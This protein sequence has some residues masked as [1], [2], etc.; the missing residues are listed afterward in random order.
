MK[1][2]HDVAFRAIR[3]AAAVAELRTII[4]TVPDAPA[5]LSGHHRRK[6]ATRRRRSRSCSPLRSGRAGRIADVLDIEMEKLDST[7]H[8]SRVEAADDARKKSITERKDQAIQKEL[9]AARRASSTNLRK[10]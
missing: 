1:R 4:A 8:Q 10:K 9:G 7:Q 5:K 3:V 6:P 2:R